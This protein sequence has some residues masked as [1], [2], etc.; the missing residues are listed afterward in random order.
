MKYSI[1]VDAM[2][3]DACK[4]SFVNYLCSILT[5]TLVIRFNG[6]HQA[7]HTVL[8]NGIR[9]TFSS[10]GSGT[11]QNIPTYWS[12][13]CTIYPT[14]L[15]NE[16]QKLKEYGVTPNIF[17]DPLCPITTPY[18]VK[19]NLLTSKHGS[20]GVGFGE[21]IKRHEN[22]YKLYYQD[23]FNITILKAKMNNIKTYYN[24]L[25]NNNPRFSLS[26]H[27][28]FNVEK[29]LE[30]WYECIEKLK[31]ENIITL[32]NIDFENY[33][34][35]IF[36]SAQGILLDM[37]FGFFPNVTR[38]NT[39][40][41]NAF[42]LLNELSLPASHLTNTK[43]YY[44]TRCYQTRHGDG[45]MSNENI[46]IDLINNE[47]EINVDSS[48]QGKFRTSPLDLDLLSYAMKC[49]EIFNLDAIKHIVVTCLDQLNIN[50]II[51]CENQEVKED[52]IINII[53]NLKIKSNIYR[54]IYGVNE[55]NFQN[56][57]KLLDK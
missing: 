40:S 44:L 22:Y 34:N 6:G 49:D 57:I 43:I 48:F 7:G 38:S 46:K 18:D 51:Y 20:V 54:I 8:H 12:K 55:G 23:L 9:H 21:T 11:L 26:T 10:F 37:D 14:A 45:F 47:N 39:T 52:N 4:G 29:S 19:Y 50:N 27:D 2:F 25:I 33:E 35:I 1:V 15:F 3:G 28:V 41:K 32:D 30:Y 36:E 13:F 5:N 31:E 16:Y 42:Q 53:N 17:F 24:D 56:N